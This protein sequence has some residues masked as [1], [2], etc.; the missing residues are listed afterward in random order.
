MNLVICLLST[1]QYLTA[2]Q[3]RAAVPGYEPDDGTERAHEAFHRMFERDKGELRELGI[4][5]EVGRT[6]MFDAED[7]YRITRRDYELPPIQLEPDEASAVGLAVRLW[8]SATL[9]E[10]AQGALVKLRAAGVDIDIDTAPASTPAIDAGEPALPVLLTAVRERRAVRFGYR[11][12][13]TPEAEQRRVQPWGVLSWRARWYLVG[14][15]DLRAAPRSFRL[16][17]VVGGVAATGAAGAFERPADL[18]LRAIVTA[19]DPEHGI[20]ALV[21]LSHGSGWLL[22]RRGE[23]TEARPDTDDVTIQGAD[24][25]WLAGQI[26]ALGTAAHALEPVE[27]VDAVIAKLRGVLR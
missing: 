12:A 2:E 21:R 4:P 13:G 17:R 19:R 16:D 11:K 6:S 26:A 22:R 5:L 24:V 10:A 3:I 15:D 8:Q 7:G 14:Y 25:D 23:I 18:D 27:L 1:Q 9:A 20:T